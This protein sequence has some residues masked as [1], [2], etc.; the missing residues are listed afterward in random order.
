MKDTLAELGVEMGY[1]IGKN[2]FLVKDGQK[3]SI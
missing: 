1:K 3:I 2:I